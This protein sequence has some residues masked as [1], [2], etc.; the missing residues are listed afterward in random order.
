[1]IELKHLLPGI[2]SQQDDGSVQVLAKSV[3]RIDRCSLCN[4][5][6]YQWLINGR[7]YLRYHRERFQFFYPY[8]H[9]GSPYF[10]R[11]PVLVFK[12]YLF[13]S[14]VVNLFLHNEGGK[15]KSDTDRQL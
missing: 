14:Q 3:P 11:S 13:I 6:F 5:L 4:R 8:I 1:M 9:V 2:H 10:H 7:K 15:D 12:S